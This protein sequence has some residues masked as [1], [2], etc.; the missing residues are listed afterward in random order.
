[1]STIQGRKHYSAELRFGGEGDLI[2]GVSD[3]EKNAEGTIHIVVEKA[4]VIG[5]DE[6]MIIPD[7][8]VLHQN[9]PN[10]FNPSTMVKYGIPEQSN[11]RLEVFNMLGQ[12]VGLF[13]NNNQSAGYYETTW[14]ASNLPSGIYL[15]SLRA[16]GLN[17]KNN[18]TQVKK[19]L[20]LK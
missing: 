12:S 6:E 18:F 8:Y 16:E 7:E 15:V 5:I 19:A 1:M 11:I 20:L 10:P 17:S 14:D 4:I 9:Y 3:S 2:W 13:V